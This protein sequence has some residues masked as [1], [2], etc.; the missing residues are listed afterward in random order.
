MVRGAWNA[1]RELMCMSEAELWA[2]REGCRNE[3]SVQSSLSLQ[4][5]S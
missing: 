2:G 1:W 4:T 5:S 3:A